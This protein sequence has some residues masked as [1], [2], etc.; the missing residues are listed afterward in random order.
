MARAKSAGRSSLR[1]HRL[2]R[3][4]IAA[5]PD[6]TAMRLTREIRELGYSG[7][8]T[9]VKCFVAAIRTGKSRNPLEDLDRTAHGRVTTTAM[10]KEEER[11]IAAGTIVGPIR[12]KRNRRPQPT[13]G[14]ASLCLLT[15]RAPGGN[16][17]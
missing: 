10:D 8:Y 4:R 2:S 13:S 5:F 12:L 17:R 15:E 1:L 6:L 11:E 3:E 14:R 7:A 9:A 16:P